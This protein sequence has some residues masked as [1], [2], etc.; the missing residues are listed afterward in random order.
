MTGES[1]NER[2]YSHPRPDAEP[3]P[4]NEHLTDVA[5]R[6]GW[7][8]HDDAQ[9]PAGTSLSDLAERIARIHD[10][11][12]LTTW[13]QQHIGV[14]SGQPGGNP[15]N[16]SPLG[17][18]L[19]YYVLDKTG[20][21]PVDC[22]VGYVAVARHH[23]SLPDAAEYVYDRTETSG[24]PPADL[25]AQ[26][27]NI[28]CHVPDLADAIIAD[29]SDGA[30]SWDDFEAGVREGT[31]F[32]AI[33][34]RVG[35]GVLNTNYDP[36]ALPEWFY[37]AVMQVWS[38]LVLADETSAASLT[39]GISVG[40]DEYRATPP[41]RESLASYL[42]GIK[43]ENEATSLSEREQNLN[44]SR[45][46]ARDDVLDAA[47][48]FIEADE[49][50]ATLTLPTGL[51]KTLTGLDA[52]MKIRDAN[53]AAD[54][55]IVYALPFTS[56]IDQIA[57][58]AHDMFDTDGTDDRLTVHHHLAETAIELDEDDDTDP[59][60]RAH[61]ASML[62][63]SWRS[64]LVV[65]TFVQLF[66]SLAGPKKSQSKKL[67]ALYD[68][69]VILD[70][71][72]SLPLDWWRLIRRLVQALT[73]EYGATV[74]A[75]TA[76][77]PHIF[78]ID[79]DRPR[80]L[81]PDPESYFAPLDRVEYAL[82]ESVE[83]YL[84]GESEPLEYGAAAHDL[85]E[86]AVPDR[87]VLAVC[88]TI[89]SAR[90]LTEEVDDAID[91]VDV[92]EIYGQR[93]TECPVADV[94]AESIATAVEQ[95]AADADAATVHLTTRLRPRDRLVLIETVKK[96]TER[97]LSLVIVSTQLIEAGVDIS[98]ECVFRD[99][100]PM[101]SI[102]QAAGRCNRSF[103]R[104]RGRVTVWWLAPPGDR[105]L[106]PSKAVYSRGESLLPPTGT[107]LTTL[108]NREGSDVLSESTVAWD[109]VRAYYDAL[110]KRG[111]G[112]EEYADLVDE[113]K[114]AE[115]G[116]LSLIDQ[117]LAV[118][119]VVARTEA[120]WQL[121]ECIRKAREEYRFDV[122][123]DLVDETRSM[124]VSVPIYRN[125]TEEAQKVRAL[126]PL[127]ADSEIRRLDGREGRSGGFFDTTT[128]LVL[129]ASTVEAR[130]L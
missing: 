100:A 44:K 71:P 2:R 130:F 56:I 40:E 106:P 8:I 120:E 63:E 122:L 84:D 47:D 92:N 76:T 13:F 4:L 35:M 20:Y 85:A 48:T 115:L 22:L 53:A 16:H 126:N 91:T 12:K 83:E 49:S 68:S 28:D 19:A 74:I 111:V 33:H 101:D 9:T 27:E 67:P 42:D 57:A 123:D 81:V 1:T 66:E 62:G 114:A 41:H 43:H 90:E 119:V 117:R 95:A 129:P 3:V 102:V 124:R 89:D 58:D 30:G 80:E 46:E 113:A 29:A 5:E 78:G 10:F 94:T 21:D 26:V 65:T 23:Q 39:T 104:E 118:D 128:G 127:Y 11:G 60:A 86:A 125:D 96:L 109:G 59:D 18:P 64:G 55:R 87:S 34:D 116:D 110:D 51:G 17:A 36:D 32:D 24:G 77:K 108:R 99:F 54:A 82:D 7:V 88:N 70:E 6:V 45:N 31:I 37:T 103:E 75:M 93:L 52:A 79:G 38:A 69:V 105:E 73:E 25:C 72:Q 97:E 50:V 14:H 15:T 121:F 98:F 112:R 107:A 61:L